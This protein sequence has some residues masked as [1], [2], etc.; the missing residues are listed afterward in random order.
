MSQLRVVPA[1]A[2]AAALGAQACPTK[3]RAE[4]PPRVEDIAA[5]GS[6]RR[7]LPFALRPPLPVTAMPALETVRR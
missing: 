4:A 3:S 1:V 6:V 2:S 7:M 5:D